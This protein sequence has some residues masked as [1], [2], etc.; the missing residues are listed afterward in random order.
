MKSNYAAT[1]FFCFLIILL[2]ATLTL[3]ILFDT[4]YPPLVEYILFGACLML[5]FVCVIFVFKLS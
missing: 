4:V 3:L 2:S 5:I 1:F